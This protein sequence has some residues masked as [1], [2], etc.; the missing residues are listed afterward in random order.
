MDTKSLG[1]VESL[2]SINKKNI[3]LNMR[4][5]NREVIDLFK[6]SF[7]ELYNS[8]Q[9]MGYK[10]VDIKYRVIEEKVNLINANKALDSELNR[11]KKAID[12]RI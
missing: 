11:F 2:I 8:L 7:Q 6:E 10:L 1:L 3:S 4:F 5:E 9:E 12:F